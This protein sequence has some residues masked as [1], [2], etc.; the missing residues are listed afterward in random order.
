MECKCFNCGSPVI[1]KPSDIKRS[2]TG[3]VYCSKSCSNSKN[4]SLFR[5]GENNPNFR[6]GISFYRKKKLLNNNNK[7]E[8]CGIEKEIVLQV[9]HID[10][11]RKN[12]NDSNLQ[13]LCANCHLIIH[14]TGK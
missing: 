2:K 6:T 9:H 5:Q 11:N 8:A 14:C 10:G 1:R 4:N 3:N 7:C 13:I 12:N